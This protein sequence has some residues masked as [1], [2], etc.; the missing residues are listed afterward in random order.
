MTLAVGHV[1]TSQQTPTQEPT[2]PGL[3][4]ADPARYAR[5]CRASAVV[6]D[7]EGHHEQAQR[8]RALA[9]AHQKEPDR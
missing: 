7:L 5:A 8:L 9:D 2:S 3:R 4:T 1:A 6:L